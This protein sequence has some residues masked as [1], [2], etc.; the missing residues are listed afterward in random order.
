[1][2]DSVERTYTTATHSS[3]F[4]ELQSGISI[5]WPVGRLLSK[6]CSIA[7]SSLTSGLEMS[8]T[9]F[10]K[11][12]FRSQHISRTRSSNPSS[13]TS[14]HHAIHAVQLRVVFDD[15]RRRRHDSLVK[16]CTCLVGGQHS[17]SLHTPSA[18]FTRPTSSQ[19]RK[20]PT[21]SNKSDLGYIPNR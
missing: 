13:S 4:L 19:H 5:Y 14:F 12:I 15:V 7:T 6:E 20:G 8:V 3:S 18:D 2:S 1:M 9:E 11:D 17:G 16:E 21:F 10:R